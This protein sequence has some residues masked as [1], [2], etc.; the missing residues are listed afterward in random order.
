MTSKILIKKFCSSILLISGV[1]HHKLT[2]INSDSLL[3]L[4]YHRILPQEK[5]PANLEPGMYVTPTTLQAHIRF[6]KKY[7]QIVTISDWE[8]TNIFCNPQ[9]AKKTLQ[10]KCL[11]SFDDGWYDFYKYAF[12]IIFE[13]N[14]PVV[15]YL[16]TEYIGTTRAFWTDRLKN[17]LLTDGG[18]TLARHLDISSAKISGTGIKRFQNNFP[19]WIVKLKGY[20]ALEINNILTYCE[21][22]L[23]I[24][25]TSTRAFMNWNE[26]RE[27]AST[28]LVTFG[29]HTANHEILTNIDIDKINYELISSMNKLRSEN[30]VTN[31]IPFCY[32]NG[33]FTPEIAKLV[34]QSGYSSGVT[35]LPGINSRLDNNFTLKRISLH[36]DIS[37]STS[38][39]AYRLTKH[40]TYNKPL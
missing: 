10:P 32:P 20:P 31:N 3:I 33:N 11:L 38:L 34:K 23:N 35:C 21:K 37:N 8:E 36:Q 6:L 1:I 26:V 24:T 4:T 27:L 25:T 15:V 17:I 22:K 16:P 2:Q 39:F 28:G 19:K 7:F 9:Q 30:V 12:P 18:F 29:S 14:I 40:I 13:E 5:V